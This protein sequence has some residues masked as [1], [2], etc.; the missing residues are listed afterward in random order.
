ME[1]TGNNLKEG[2]ERAL[3][4]AKSKLE[5]ILPEEVEKNTGAKWNGTGYEIPWFN[6]TANPEDSPIDEKIIQ[7]HYLI[8]NGPKTPRGVYVNY[9]QVPGGII[10]NDNF[11]KRCINPMVK[12]F[13]GNLEGFLEMGM[14]MGGEKQ[15]LG[16]VS[17][18]LRPLPYVP[19]TFV[20]WQGDDELKDSGNILFDETVFDWFCAED[21]VVLAA[22]CVY[23]MIRML[24][25]KA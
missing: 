14:L 6:G 13:A 18:T 21:V 20:I 11:I 5:K 8:A 17:F 25:S 23:K 15:N 9:K 4:L 16:H 22:I 10:Y 2:Y 1:G 7:Y 3:N 19:V 12:T 24:K